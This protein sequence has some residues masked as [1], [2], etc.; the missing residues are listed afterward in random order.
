LGL[1]IVVFS[2]V[3]LFGEGVAA[4]LEGDGAVDAAICC[5]LAGDMVETV[6]GFAADVVLVDVAQHGGLGE[7]RALAAACP[8]IPIVALALGDASSDVIACADAGFISY[9]PRDAPISQLR[10]IIDMA[11]RGEVQ[12][13]PK[14][15]GALLRE[16]RLRQR[17]GLEDQGSD[18]LT[19]RECGVLR[20]LGR[21]C[22][23]KE[24]AQQLGVSEATIKNHVHEVL[25][26]LRVRRRAQA[27]ARLREQPWIARIG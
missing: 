13:G 15:S 12:C 27:A 25:A 21:G 17:K 1:R 22:S 16:L 3:R 7:G 23:N 14:V 6:T 10:A 11:M 20:L 24:I 19:R 5:H 4:C 26:K 9:V 8:D 2:P 18:P